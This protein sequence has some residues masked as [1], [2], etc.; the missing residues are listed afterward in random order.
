SSYAHFAPLQNGSI[1]PYVP[2]QSLPVSPSYTSTP[3]DPSLP[4]FNLTSGKFSINSE[5]WPGNHQ[6]AANIWNGKLISCRYAQKYDSKAGFWE[7]LTGIPASLANAP[8]FALRGSL[9]HHNEIAVDE[10]PR[11]SKHVLYSDACA[12]PTD[13][14]SFKS[15]FN[16][17]KQAAIQHI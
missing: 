8:G 13:R 7:G 5:K 12:G 6:Q 1:A 11:P 16:W 4:P 10:L 9:P 15:Q 2:G 17:R 3:A 14:Q